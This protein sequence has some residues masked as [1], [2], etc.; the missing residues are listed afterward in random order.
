MNLQ[1]PCR[2]EERGEWFEKKWVLAEGSPTT[3]DTPSC[4]AGNLHL[5]DDPRKL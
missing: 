1:D 4:S 3:L 2:K 5:E